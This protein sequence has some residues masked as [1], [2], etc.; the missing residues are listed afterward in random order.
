MAPPTPNRK[1]SHDGGAH[2]GPLPVADHDA[3]H[4][5][6]DQPENDKYRGLKGNLDE[7]DMKEMYFEEDFKF[8]MP[9]HLRRPQV[10][11]RALPPPRTG[12][13]GSSPVS[14]LPG[15]PL[16]EV[17]EP[18]PTYSGS[19]ARDKYVPS[20]NESSQ[21]S[22]AFR[23][24]G[25][26]D[27]YTGLAQNAVKSRKEKDS[28]NGTMCGLRRKIFWIVVAI[29]IFIIVGLAVGLGVGLNVSSGDYYSYPIAANDFSNI[30]RTP[31]ELYLNT[32]LSSVNFTDEYGHENYV[33]FY[34]LNSK[35]LCRSLWNSSENTWTAGVVSNETELLKLGT[36]I[37]S[38]LF[39]H[40]ETNRDV[41]VYAVKTDNRI[42]GRVSYQQF[43]G[44]SLQ[45][46]ADSTISLPGASPIIGAN[47]TIVSNGMESQG[48]FMLDAIIYQNDNGVIHVLSNNNSNN[49]NTTTSNWTS[50]PLPSDNYIP[51]QGSPMALAPVYQQ[52]G[53][54]LG[55]YVYAEEEWL[56]Q[57]ILSDANNITNVLDDEGP[58]SIYTPMHYEGAMYQQS[59]VAV[60]SAGWNDTSDDLK[61]QV[62]TMD[63]H[64]SPYYTPMV[65]LA[66]YQ[67]GDWDSDWGG[68]RDWV[69]TMN[70]DVNPLTIAVNQAGRVYGTAVQQGVVKIFEWAWEGGSS[71]KPIGVVN[72]TIPIG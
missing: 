1:T 48:G 39:W 13:Q 17:V 10:H 43:N 67:Y 59:S 52:A 71:Y 41:R 69:R 62:L 45:Y 8:I 61:L 30:S 19:T 44:S 2:D 51:V 25:K 58:R 23:V 28:K 29:A 24:A 16:P 9:E 55:L 3:K 49:G 57:I 60:F 64:F 12:E 37:S 20:S 46:W 65:E 4:D 50:S 40:N 26:V 11:G 63:G 56:R 38:S 33:V 68:S 54:R 18:R 31:T 42:M 15:P 36:P 53:S 7:Q 14:E 34:Q 47:S 6:T 22:F 70:A 35:A 66:M 32:T 5:R 27:H 72:T 21:P